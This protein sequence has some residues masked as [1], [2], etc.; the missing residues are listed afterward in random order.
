MGVLSEG[1]KKES[2]HPER[3]GAERVRR[4]SAPELLSSDQSKGTPHY[5]NRHLGRI[6]ALPTK[7]AWASSETV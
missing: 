6:G 3:P 7:L 4:G 1:Q 5:W 2:V